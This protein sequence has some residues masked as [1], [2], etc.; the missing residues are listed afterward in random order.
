MSRRQEACSERCSKD[1][2]DGNEHETL[3]DVHGL[4]GVCEFAVYVRAVV[5]FGRGLRP[6]GVWADDVSRSATGRT[7]TLTLTLRTSPAICVQSGI[8]V[9]VRAVGRAH[10]RGFTCQAG[11]EGKRHDRAKV[12]TMR[13]QPINDE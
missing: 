10:Q 4:A 7:A 3:C 9:G 1:L 13:A 11:A 6:A 12:I 8:S 5:V 2:A